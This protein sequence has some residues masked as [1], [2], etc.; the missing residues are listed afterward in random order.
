MQS[1]CKV[2]SNVAKNRLYLVFQGTIPDDMAKSAA[3]RV[4]EEAR[5]LRPGFSVV[6]DLSQ[7]QPTG[8][9]GA[10][11]IRRVQAFLGY[12]GIE[13]IIRILPEVDGGVAGQFEKAAGKYPTALTAGS[14]E[15]ADAILDRV[16]GQ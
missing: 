13:R 15:E 7:A 14:I 16:Q 6:N 11:E 12:M 9:W 1:I 8:P 5:H 2:W 4:I 3:E 10:A